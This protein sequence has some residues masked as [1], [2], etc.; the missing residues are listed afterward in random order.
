MFLYRGVSG[1]GKTTLLDILSF[2]KTTGSISGTI[3]L[4]GQVPSK[5]QISIVTGYVEQFDTLF[6]Y[7]TVYESLMF[8]A[9]LKLPR[10]LSL[11]IRRQIVEEVI[12]ILELSDIRDRLI[13]NEKTPGLSPSQLKR[14]NI[15]VELVGN[16]AVLFLDEPTT[17]MPVV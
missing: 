14:V 2:R 8:V 5:N 1:A 10:D 6:C 7:Q 4:N 11:G 9:T 12:D 16:P 15:A 17:G 13:G 3:L